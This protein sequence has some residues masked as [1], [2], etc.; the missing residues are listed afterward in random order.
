MK[1]KFLKLL[2]VIIVLVCASG[3]SLENF[4]NV[5]DSMSS[6]VSVYA[7][8]EIIKCVKDYIGDDICPKNSLYKGKYRSCIITNLEKADLQGE[9]YALFFCEKSVDCGEIHILFLS[10]VE[11]KWKIFKD[12]KQTAL[13]L[14]KVYI[15]DVDS[16]GNNELE[17][18]FKSSNKGHGNVY[19]YRFEN[20]DIVAVNIPS[21]F[22][23]NFKDSD[24]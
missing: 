11:N 7:Q 1:N 4:F 19:T 2:L 5:A 13:D 15:Q 17:F 23:N 6:P 22:F 8:E 16:D 24:G 12:I 21:K 10:K 18:V 14:E 9:E 20:G 3:C